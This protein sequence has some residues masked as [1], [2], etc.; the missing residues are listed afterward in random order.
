MSSLRR[1]LRSIVVALIAATGV[2]NPGAT[3]VADPPPGFVYGAP[4]PPPPPV[5]YSDSDRR[6]D[7][8]QAQIEA[9]RAYARAVERW[10]A[11]NCVREQDNRTVAGAVIG[12]VL[13]ALTGGAVGRGGGAAVG[14]AVGAVAGAAVGAGSTSP[15]CPPG[16]VVR[17]GAPPFYYVYHGPEWVYVAPPDYRPWIWIEGHW[18]YRPYPYHH[19]WRLRHWR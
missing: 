16:Y 18:I 4:P 11:A 8:V 15:G 17:T 19:F 6:R 12:G 7:L 1:S 14:G 13:G 3:A 9:D 5:G 10:A 2:V